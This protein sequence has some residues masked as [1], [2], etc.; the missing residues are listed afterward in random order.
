M[1]VKL[2]ETKFGVQPASMRATIDN[3]DSETLSKCSQ[4]LFTAKVVQEV[5]EPSLSPKAIST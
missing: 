2:L 4:R 1:F 3:F 5:I